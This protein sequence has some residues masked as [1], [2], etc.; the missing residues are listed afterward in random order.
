LPAKS[1]TSRLSSD[2]LSAADLVTLCEKDVQ[3]VVSDISDTPL[4]AHNFARLAFLPTYAQAEWHFGAEEYIAAKLYTSPP[5]T[6][7]VKGA[8]SKSGNVW[9]YWVHDYNDD[10]L[11]ILRIVSKVPGT[12]EGPEATMEIADVLRAAQA[13]AQSWALK[14]V[15]IWNPEEDTLLACKLILGDAEVKVQ[16]RTD[17]SI[18]CFRWKASE[19]KDVDWISIEKY[20][21]C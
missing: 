10:K 18:P 8:K 9:A 15:V 4:A 11:T 3:Y 6:P 21:W 13:E 7:S 2:S 19:E 16:E 1:I 12:P 20:S 17:G 14:K 5:R